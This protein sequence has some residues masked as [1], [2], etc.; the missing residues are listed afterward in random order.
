MYQALYR[1]Y[2]PLLF[3][4]VVGQTT[5]VKILKNSILNN[6][7]GHAYLFFGPRGTG[8]TSL[9]KIFA[10]TIN[11]PHLKNGEICC[12]CNSCK[13]MI[14][15]KSVDII[16]IDAASNNG[17]DE[18]RELRSKVNLVPNQLKYKVYIIDE[19]HMLSIGAFNA[20]LKTLEEPPEHIVF[21]LAT[22]DPQKVPDTIKSRCQCFNFKRISDEDIVRKL[23]EICDAEKINVERSIL[24]SIASFSNGGMR[25]S[26]SSLD[27]LYSACGKNITMQDYIEINNLIDKD[28]LKIFLDEILSGNVENYL[29]HIEMI[30]S[31]GKNIVHIFEL[32]LKQGRDILV[33]HYVYSTSFDYDLILLEDFVFYLNEHLFDIKKAS[34]SRIYVEIMILKFIN[35]KILDRGESQIISREIICK[36]TFD[37][38]EENSKSDFLKEKEAENTSISLKENFDNDNSYDKIENDFLQKYKD[39]MDIRLNNTLCKADKNILL[40]VKKNMEKLKEYVFD[41]KIGY[42]VCSLMDGT[43]RV[44]SEENI[45][46][47]VEYN[48]MIDSNIKNM[49]KLKDVLFQITGLTQNLA[50]ITDECWFIKKQEYI[51]RMQSGE[52]YQYLSEPELP[53]M[54]EKDC[55][56][57]ELVEHA[58]ELFGDIVEEEK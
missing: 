54:P 21:V 56:K 19:V 2:R 9:A 58:K 31:Y 16:E 3:S 55:K 53:I 37:N 20:L 50:F 44:A 18:I 22:T 33:N 13:E 7:V 49:K 43:V 40:S 51:Q 41:Q 38:K 34:N 23:E 27:M 26:L 15:E 42:L 30:N 45:L 46:I 25:D 4:D 48:S 52:S 17:V 14:E 6:Q 10:R 57:N 47:S 32:M 35:E 36:Q 39:L 8:K 11:C 29:K 12:Q 28:E 24:Q 5:I 1:K